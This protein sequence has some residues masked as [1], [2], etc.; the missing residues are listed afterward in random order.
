MFSWCN[1]SHI[2]KKTLFL[3]PGP[4]GSSQE[5]PTIYVGIKQIRFAMNVTYNIALHVYVFYIIGK[6]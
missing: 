1:E 6:F 4:T 5:T 3:W 2:I